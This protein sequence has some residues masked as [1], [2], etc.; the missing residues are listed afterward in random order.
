MCR[1]VITEEEIINAG[2]CC[3]SLA[4]GERARSIE[5]E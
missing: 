4:H 3:V 5:M 1:V 2:L